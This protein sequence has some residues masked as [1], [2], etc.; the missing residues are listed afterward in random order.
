MKKIL[1]I[2]MCAVLVAVLCACGAQAE[3]EAA[4]SPYSDLIARLEAGD[5]DGARSLIDRMENREVVAETVSPETQS[6]EVPEQEVVTEP[7]VVTEPVVMQDCEIVE[8]TQYN[9]RDYF[10]FQEQYYIAD[11]SGC[12]QYITL[13]E[14]YRDRLIAVEDAEIEVSYLLCEAHGKIDLD[15]E[16]FRSEYF[17]ILSRERE[18][19]TIALNRDGMGWISQ[20]LYYSKKGYFPEFA[21]D[22]ELLSGSGKLYLT[23]Q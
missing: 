21:M 19:K 15:A 12:S 18:T 13:L 8:L 9:I 7:P 1:T 16:Q 20:M 17:D 10:T 3:P 23:R 14:E 11:K 22:V 2:C 6:S 5:Y 4:V